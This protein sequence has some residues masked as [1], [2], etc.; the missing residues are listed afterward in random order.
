[1]HNRSDIVYIYDG[2]Y[3]GLLCCIFESF[4]KKELPA[5]IQSVEA[6]QLT[7]YQT[8]LI[9]TDFD[10]SERV[11]RGIINKA[12]HDAYA[13]VRQG[14]YT[15]LANKERVILDYVRICMQHGSKV[16]RMIS[17]DT[18]CALQ[19]A[20]RYLGSESHKLKGFIRFSM[21][22]G[23]LVSIIEPNNFVLPNIAPHF[24]DRYS[25]E[26]FVIYDQ[27]HGAAL[28][29]RPHEASIIEVDEYDAPVYD[30]DEEFYRSLWK[31][32]YNTIAIDERYNP[33]CRMGFMPK[34]YWKHLTEMD[35]RVTARRAS[36][37]DKKIEKRY[38]ATSAY[39]NK[40]YKPSPIP[41][42][43]APERL[44]ER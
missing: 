28:I 20:V 21:H 22:N 15:C 43:S 18:V 4:E 5:D 30:Q 26:A 35:P 1:M 38:A 3:D 34:R 2:S 9:E 36:I 29:Y 6:P 8:R 39:S 41:R 13:L 12:S 11:K 23:I 14:Y 10:K 17:D 31:T 42:P 24:C 40:E 7:L 33:R 27:S 19:G 25:E 32:F 44:L 37:E 16:L